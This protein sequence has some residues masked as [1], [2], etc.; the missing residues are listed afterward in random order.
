[1]KYIITGGAGFIGSH[2]AEELLKKVNLMAGRELISDIFIGL[3]SD[4]PNP[5]QDK[6]DK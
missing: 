5:A 4:D 3:A 2:I 1:M 6:V